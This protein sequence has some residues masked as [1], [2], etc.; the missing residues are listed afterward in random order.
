MLTGWRWARQLY[1]QLADTVP[2]SL[3]IRSV[4]TQSGVLINF[5]GYP[6]VY[7]LSIDGSLLYGHSS[8][9]TVI[10][11]AVATSSLG[12][13]Q[14]RMSVACGERTMRSIILTRR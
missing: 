13:E 8:F 12:K 3:Y 4:R 10:S 2:L 1:F 6:N 14:Q 5:A 11:Q 9:D 7:A